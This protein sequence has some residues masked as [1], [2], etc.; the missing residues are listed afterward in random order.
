MMLEPKEGNCPKCNGN[1]L[2]WSATWKQVDGSCLGQTWLCMSCHHMW[3][4]K[5]EEDII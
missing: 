5:D 3:T 4:P 1:R 2:C